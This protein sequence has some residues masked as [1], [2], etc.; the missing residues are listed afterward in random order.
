VVVLIGERRAARPG[1]RMAAAFAEEASAM[2]LVRGPETRT[3]RA[4]AAARR[5]L[6]A[7]DWI[8]DRVLVQADILVGLHRNLGGRASSC[9]SFRLVRAAP[10][11]AGPKRL[12][13][14]ARPRAQGRGDS[15][16]AR[17]R[18]DDE[19]A[20]PAPRAGVFRSRHVAWCETGRKAFHEAPRRDGLEG[21]HPACVGAGEALGVA[22]P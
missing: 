22:A 21:V 2:R 4:A 19:E 13:G 9:R 11:V 3:R 8:A 1:H 16:A 7:R 6:R 14:R 17:R 20:V 12:N 18:D 15:V 5:G 10:G